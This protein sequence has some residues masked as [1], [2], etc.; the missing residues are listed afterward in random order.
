LAKYGLTE[1]T[2]QNMIKGSD[3][4][5]PLGLYTFKDSQKSVVVDGNI[6]TIEDLKEMKI[7]VTPST[8]GA[9]AQGQQ[10]SSAQGQTPQA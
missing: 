3:V 8:G 5:A 1:E 9:S 4:T 6:T 2:V 7:P 10:Q